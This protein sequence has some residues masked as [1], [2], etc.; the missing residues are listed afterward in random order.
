MKM[1][2]YLMALIVTVPIFGQKGIYES[3]KF[4]ELSKNHEILAILPFFT[5]LDL[6]DGNTQE[7]YEYHKVKVRFLL[8]IRFP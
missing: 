2:F 3:D 1:I 4:D 6:E 8:K 7:R 5:K